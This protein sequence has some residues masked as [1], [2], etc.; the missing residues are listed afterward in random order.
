MLLDLGHMPRAN[1]EMVRGYIGNP[2]YESVWCPYSRGAN[3]ESLK[4]QRSIWE[5]DQELVKR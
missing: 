4:Q 5:E 2:K 3:T 1:K